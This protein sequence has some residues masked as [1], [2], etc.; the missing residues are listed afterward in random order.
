MMTKDFLAKTDPIPGWLSRREG[1]LLYYF[2][3]LLGKKGEVVE[4]GSF[5]GK[6]TVF[7]AQAIKELKTGKV[8]A[9][10]PHLG[11][12][13][14]A[15]SG[16]KFG[17]TFNKF[18]ANLRNFGLSK[19]VLAIRKTS[20]SASKT[21]KKPIAVLNIDGLHEY[22]FAKQDLELWLPHLVSG[23]VV[24][25]HDAFS[26]F[27]EVFAA[28]K[29]TIFKSAKFRFVGVS[30]SQ[31]FAIKGRPRNLLEKVDLWRSIFFI[32]LASSIWQNKK[33]PPRLADFLV[34]RVLK[35]FYLNWLMVQLW[36]S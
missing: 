9:I 31:I 26:P 23:G 27:P 35:I 28:I 30:E 13:H 10:D 3:K 1:Q 34:K 4:V 24:I 16:P 14:V 33:I 20:F 32:S 17:E 15:K 29:E 12:T 36:F 11:Q 19:Q 6:S 25:C 8:T 2:A 7:L 5:Q 22:Q 21:W 18:K